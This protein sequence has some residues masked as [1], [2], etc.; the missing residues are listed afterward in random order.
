MEF[1]M[2]AQA[3]ADK[4]HDLRAEAGSW[5][6]AAREQVGMSQR[7]L[8]NVLGLQVYTFI[9]QVEGGKGRVPPERYEAYA[10][11]LGVDPGEF[12]RKM[13]SFYEPTTYELIFK[14]NEA[15]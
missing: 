1:G 12:A 13:L 15:S 6:K 7:E 4:R 5:L 2:N 3:V 9:S 14:G 11:A 8:A 10:K